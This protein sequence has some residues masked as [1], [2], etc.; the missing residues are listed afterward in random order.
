ME[1]EKP[2]IE[3]YHQRTF[4]EKMNVTFEFIR[5]NW[6][7]LLKYSFYLITPICL[8]QSFAMNSFFSTSLG[9]S[10]NSEV[11]S[12]FGSSMYSIF[13][14][15]GVMLLCMMIGT[16]IMTAFTYAMMQTYATR[17]N[18][19][20]DV[21]LNDFKGTLT[22][23]IWKYI[24]II[25]VMII[26]FI[27]MSFGLSFL[28]VILSSAALLFTA[29]FFLV[30]IILLVP[31]IMII[32]TYIFERD[33]IITNAIKKALNLG[34][35]TFWS[36]LGFF[37]VLY[38]ISFVIQTLVAIP[39]FL[40]VVIGTTFS[41]ASESTMNQSIIFKFAMYILGLIQSFGTYISMIIGLIGLAFQY[42]HA[43]EK[44]EGITIE[45]NISNF[46]EL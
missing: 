29:F 38:I 26:A 31:M 4:S 34:F 3:F 11:E 10:L 35:T 17:E 45:S 9:M 15:Y 36:M 2:R 33:I 7:P 19:L 32:P 18:R 16:I 42:F 12:A 30:F 39:W 6:K 37:I 28:T 40:T 44:V 25:F 20:Q 23:N 1:Y 21:N 27:S 46:D 41:I 14:N 22:K 24:I 13:A 5:E 43:R 8:I